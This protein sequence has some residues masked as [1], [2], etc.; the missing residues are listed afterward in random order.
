MDK[1]WGFKSVVLE[2]ER[3][4]LYFIKD[5]A[6]KVLTNKFKGHSISILQYHDC[7]ISN[8]GSLL[9]LMKN[10]RFLFTIS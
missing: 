8:K 3:I 10:C 1:R 4:N 7:E 5:Y 9:C 6:A 2:Q